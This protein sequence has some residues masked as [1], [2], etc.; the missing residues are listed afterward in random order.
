MIMLERDVPEKLLLYEVLLKRI[1]PAHEEYGRM[2][3][4][5]QNMKKG[6]FGELRSDREW[7]EIQIIQSHYLFHSY[8]SV[9]QFGHTHQIDTLFL[10]RRFILVMESKDIGGII[11]FDDKTRQF[12]Q[13]RMDGTKVIFSNPV[14]QVL[15]HKAFVELEL[16]KLGIRIPII[17]VIT[18]TDPSTTFGATSQEVDV[19]SITGLRSK[20]VK[21]FNRFPEV[22]SENQLDYVKEHFL[23][24]YKKQELNRKYPN[25]PLLKGVLCSSCKSKMVHE[26]KGFRCVRCGTKNS[27]GMYEAMHDYRLLYKDWITNS[28]FR[29]YVG[30][31]SMHTAT[32]MLKRMNLKAVGEKRYRKYLI[33]KDIFDK[34]NRIRNKAIRKKN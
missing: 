22:L 8:E 5:Y 31:E 13:T 32:K 15:R 23:M 11:D 33:P 19:F 18:I 24:C 1:D 34:A 10:C 14:D 21:L 9:N 20:L 6:Y 29:D 12:T 30:V 25:V 26:R 4:T 16:M 27:L 2:L 7:K 3:L 17:A 28:E